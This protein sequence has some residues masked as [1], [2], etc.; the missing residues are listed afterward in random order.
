MSKRLREGRI[1]GPVMRVD[2]ILDGRIRGRFPFQLTAGAQQRV[3]WEIVRDLQSGDADESDC[4]KGMWEAGRRLLRCM[5]CWWR[6]QS[7]M[8]AVLLAPTEVLAEQRHYLTL[9]SNT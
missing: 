7:K 3:V 1:S 5:R 9:S 6:W 4:F 2:K 8:Q